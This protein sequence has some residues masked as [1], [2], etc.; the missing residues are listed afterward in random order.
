CGKL[1]EAAGPTPA[2]PRMRLPS[3]PTA[4]NTAMSG[5]PPRDGPCPAQSRRACA[6]RPK[7]PSDRVRNRCRDRRSGLRRRELRLSLE[8]LPRWHDVFEIRHASWTNART[9]GLFAMAAA[10]HS[11]ERL[12]SEQELPARES[13]DFDVVIVGAGPAGLSAAIRLK[14]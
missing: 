6:R 1:L 2:K 10:T 7:A 5:S 3:R 13:M 12:M 11:K 8:H 14:Q 9:R 4:T